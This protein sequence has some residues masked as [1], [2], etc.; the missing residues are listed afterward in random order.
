MMAGCLALALCIA[1]TTGA[2]TA[3][4]EDGMAADYDISCDKL[5][6]DFGSV[7]AEI[8]IVPK[9]FTVEKSGDAAFSLGM[10]AE[11]DYDAF[12]LMFQYDYEI[13]PDPEGKIIISEQPDEYNFSV[14]IKE[15]CLPGDYSASYIFYNAEYSD[16]EHMHMVQ[17]GV[18]ATIEEPQ[19]IVNSVEIT[20][21]GGTVQTGKSY[22]FEAKVE[23]KKLTDKSVN[24]D[25]S[26]YRSADTY[27]TAQKDNSAILTIGSN[28]NSSSITVIATS[29]QD[30]LSEKSNPKGTADLT[31]QKSSVY[32]DTQVSDNNAG[33]IT[34][35]SYVTYG[36]SYDI[37]AKA[38]AGYKF[39]RFVENGSTISQS[40]SIKLNN[41]TSDREIVA[42]FEKQKYTIKATISPASSGWVENLG[43]YEYGEQ[44]WLRAV[45]NEGYDF[46]S[47]VISNQIV[48]TDVEYLTKALEADMTITA[49]FKKQEARKIMIA[50]GTADNGG[51]ISPDGENLVEE[52]KSATYKMIPNSGYKVAA[53]AVDGV[54]IG[55]VETY[56]FSN[57][58]EE[59]SIAV[60][61]EKI[62]EETLKK[63]STGTTR[64]TSN[65]DGDDTED[66][67][68]DTMFYID[69]LEDEEE[70]EE[71]KARI[72]SEAEDQFENP[73][74]VERKTIIEEPEDTEEELPQTYILEDEETAKA[75]SADALLD[76][77][78][79][80][81]STGNTKARPISIPVIKFVV[82]IIMVIVCASIGYTYYWLFSNTNQKD[83]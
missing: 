59:H 66:I 34:S 52:G 63:S 37:T 56:T 69:D 15:D 12:S 35:G 83:Q 20:P 67:L 7:E 61:F 11:G 38:N 68:D 73:G 49:N 5:A 2:V 72:A 43:T 65:P 44:V 19:P 74:I 82:A 57:V 50:S 48:S 41:I 4:A 13:T 1:M 79:L 54:S 3:Y 64:T 22:L 39:V 33:T 29:N 45:P 51:K 62:P 10:R 30:G 23:G 14:D 47:W 24:W 76:A 81:T 21:S 55:A 18:F 17:V 60:S 8:K 25:V 46:V 58:Y 36:G 32:V 28:E 70:S 71:E 27:I 75:A 80:A 42:E 53:V 31:V 6:L 40:S 26:G 77:D 78:V 16:E 9:N